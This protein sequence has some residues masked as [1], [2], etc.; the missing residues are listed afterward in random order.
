[1]VLNNLYAPG[2]SRGKFCLTMQQT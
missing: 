2:E 1:M